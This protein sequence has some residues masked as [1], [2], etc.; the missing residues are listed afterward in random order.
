MA[1]AVDAAIN[2]EC[3]MTQQTIIRNETT[4]DRAACRVTVEEVFEIA[5]GLGDQFTTRDVADIV[6]ARGKLPNVSYDRIERSVRAAIFWLVERELASVSGEITRVISATSVSK[7]QTYIIHEGR[8]WNKKARRM[9]RSPVD[10][11]ALNRAFGVC[12]A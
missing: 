7:P 3:D 10:F 9:E 12:R 4:L 11:N 6:V 5:K 1:H 8:T 2:T